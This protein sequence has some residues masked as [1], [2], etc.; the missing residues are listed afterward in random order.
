MI[1]SKITIDVDLS[2]VHYISS[3]GLR[4]LYH[5]FM[6]LRGGA[7]TE[8]DAALKKGLRDGSYKSPNLKLLNP[9]P[10]VS[11]ALQTSGFDMFLEIHR[12]LKEA[13][14]SF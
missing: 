14:A 2:E 1:D 13:V 8:D 4:A 7:S 12:R 10:S 11:Q 6:L 5:I 9:S 3:S